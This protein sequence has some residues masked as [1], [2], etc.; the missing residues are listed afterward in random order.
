MAFVASLS[1]VKT[2]SQTAT[3][4]GGGMEPIGMLSPSVRGLVVLLGPLDRRT[5]TTR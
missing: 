2:F 3:I 4:S 1:V 5:L